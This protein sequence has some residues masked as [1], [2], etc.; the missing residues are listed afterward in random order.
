MTSYQEKFNRSLKDDFKSEL[1]G[2]FEDACVALIMPLHELS[3]DIIFR[4][5][6]VSDHFDI[7]NL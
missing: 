5:L 1:G 7:L 4:T 3:A 2:A 6:T